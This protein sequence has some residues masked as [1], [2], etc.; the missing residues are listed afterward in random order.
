MNRFRPEVNILDPY[1]L[2]IKSFRKISKRLYFSDDPI[3]KDI[4]GGNLTPVVEP[5]PVLEVPDFCFH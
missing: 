5:P 3:R 1:R 4:G 2:T